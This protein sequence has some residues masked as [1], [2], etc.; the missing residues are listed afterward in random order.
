MLEARCSAHPPSASVLVTEVEPEASLLDLLGKVVLNRGK[1][2]KLQ[3]ARLVQLGQ[4]GQLAQQIQQ[5][6]FTAS[7]HSKPALVA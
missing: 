3:P 6:L 1:G 7:K 4:L 2:R 5:L